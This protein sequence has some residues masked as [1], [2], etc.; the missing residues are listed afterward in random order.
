MRPKVAR[1]GM[2]ATIST[3]FLVCPVSGCRGR[4][5]KCGASFQG[6]EATGQEQNVALAAVLRAVEADQSRFVTWVRP[7]EGV[8]A[9]GAR[10]ST[11]GSPNLCDSRFHQSLHQGCRRQLVQR[12]AHGPFRRFMSSQRDRVRP[13]D[14]VRDRIQAAVVFEGSVPNERPSVEQ[15]PWNPVAEVLNGARGCGAD[16]CTKVAQGTPSRSW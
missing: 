11:R 10:S 12:K 6:L 1:S 15:E 3:R 9:Q 5:E 7:V 13:A 8:S 4:P 16:S 14:P 2:S